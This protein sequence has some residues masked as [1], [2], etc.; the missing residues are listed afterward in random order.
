MQQ[1]LAGGLR[2]AL[3]AS[4]LLVL[5]T[6]DVA[7]AA[8]ATYECAIPTTRAYRPYYCEMGSRDY[9]A[10]ETCNDPVNREFDSVTSG[11]SGILRFSIDYAGASTTLTILEWPLPQ[12]KILDR[13]SL[14]MSQPITPRLI[15]V[16]PIC[17][18]SNCLP[19]GSLYVGDLRAAMAKPWARRSEPDSGY[20]Y[21]RASNSSLTR[22]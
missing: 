6:A 13:G 3:M 8:A 5:G 21:R 20:N 22:L 4:A 2:R 18:M 14:P 19:V 9:M 15:G 17:A 12:G 16:Q 11:G 10:V 7:A 1:I